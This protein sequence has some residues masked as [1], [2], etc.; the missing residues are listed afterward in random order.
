MCTPGMAPRPGSIHAVMLAW[1]PRALR[2]RL[3]LCL[4]MQGTCK[5]HVNV[6]QEG[7][8]AGIRSGCVIILYLP[9]NTCPDVWKNFVWKKLNLTHP[10]PLATTNIYQ[11]SPVAGLRPMIPPDKIRSNCY[12]LFIHIRILENGNLVGKSPNL[13]GPVFKAWL[14]HHEVSV[15]FIYFSVLLLPPQ[16]KEAS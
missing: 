6:P 8:R 14:H 7:P 12:Q 9:A 16:Q 15:K 10:Q 13:S 4:V 1:Q 11:N 5:F 2:T 3:Q